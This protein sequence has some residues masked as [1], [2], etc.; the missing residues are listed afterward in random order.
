MAEY[1]ITFKDIVT[2][3]GKTAVELLVDSDFDQELTEAG[4]FAAAVTDLFNS[5]KLA[6][7]GAT[8]IS[9]IDNE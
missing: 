3:D 2:E 1:V 8:L 9:E 4:I 6:E 5:Q 7:H